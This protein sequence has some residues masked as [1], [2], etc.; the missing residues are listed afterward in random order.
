M[1]LENTL[2]EPL[3]IIIKL[4]IY[5]LIYAIHNNI[6]ILLGHVRTGCGLG[7]NLFGDGETISSREVGFS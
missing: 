2:I 3:K 1:K 5:Y 6:K 4:L 7:T